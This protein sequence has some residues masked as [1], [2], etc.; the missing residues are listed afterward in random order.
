MNLGWQNQHIPLTFICSNFS[1]QLLTVTQAL[2]FLLDSSRR[3]PASRQHI[4]FS[5]SN[6]EIMDAPY[7]AARTGLQDTVGNFK[8]RVLKRYSGFTQEDSE[9]GRE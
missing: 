9:S 6:R 3:E 2:S 4:Y 8:S 5:K 7:A 1:S